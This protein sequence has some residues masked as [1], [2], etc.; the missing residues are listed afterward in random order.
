M[1]DLTGKTVLITGASSGIGLACAKAFAKQGARLL[2][3]A[4]R[5]A[6]L[7][8]LA[9]ELRATYQTEVHTLLLDVREQVAVKQV[10]AQLPA[11]WRHI[12]ILVNNAGLAR[13]LSPVQDGNPDDWD[14]M[15]DTNIKGLLYVTHA[16]LPGMLERQ[17]GHIINLGSIAGY[18]TYPGGTVYCATKA[19]VQ[20]I[21]QGLK[22]DL[23][24]TPLRVSEIA[25]GMVQTPFSEVRFHGDKARADA[26]YADVQ[27][28]Q[29]DDIAEAV[30][31][32]ASQPAHVDVMSMTVFPVDQSSATLFHRQAKTDDS[33]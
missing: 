18:Q 4:R 8:Q 15:I 13:D 23:H 29:A 21:T 27:A 33:L 24:G 16:V 20:A 9:D 2:L 31:F 28:L 14:E 22:M 6:L 26:V 32:C 25:P 3:S 10:L 30:V 7:T 1:M 17:C 19:A 11:H 12:D 5:Q